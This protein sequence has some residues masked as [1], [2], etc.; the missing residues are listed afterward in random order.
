[1]KKNYSSYQAADF[2][3]DPE[4]LKWVKYPQQNQSLN[5]FW[6][7][8]LL[9][10]PEKRHEVE[11]ARQLIFA[12]LEQNYT[13]SD[14]KQAE[15]W[16]R[17]RMTLHADEVNSLES[18]QS[19]KHTA[20]FWMKI[21][22]GIILIA[23]VS[24]GTYYLYPAKQI[25]QPAA[26]VEKPVFVKEENLTTSGRTVV[27]PDGSSI[28]LQPHSF[29]QYPKGLGGEEREV[30]LTG[31]AFFEV[32]RDP[33]RPFLVHTNEIV[34]RVLGTSFT[35]R[36]FENENVVVR[37]RTGKVS[38][39]KSKESKKGDAVEGVVLSPNQQVIYE[40]EEM[41]LSKSL[42]EDPVVLGTKQFYDFEFKDT[43]VSKVFEEIEAAYGVDIVYDEEAHAH[44]RLNASLTDAPLYDK[45]KLV[46]KGINAH[47]ELLDSQ[48]VI[49][50]KGCN[51]D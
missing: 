8:W 48:I 12:I 51:A 13:P 20:L 18:N 23:G 3:R 45:L 40:R 26:A 14:A 37:V 34:T 19:E 42:I 50:G 38:V 2:A 9:E 44:C 17:I 22:A 32:K 49:Y 36:S 6:N 31:E 7:S 33:S 30:Y 28:V 35:V 27:L 46:C 16:A 41:K 43:P 24:I 21:A 4:F 39:F 10:N 15:L 11:E 47:Y 29:I 5:L 1:M 25:I